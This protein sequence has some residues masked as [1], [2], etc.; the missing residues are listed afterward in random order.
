MDEREVLAELG[1]KQRDELRDALNGPVGA[2]T[3]AQKG[4]ELDFGKCVHERR[5]QRLGNQ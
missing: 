4:A 1:G 2:R 3:F 5:C